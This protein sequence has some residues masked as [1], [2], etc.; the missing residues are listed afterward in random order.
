MHK[1]DSKQYHPTVFKRTV[2]TERRKLTEEERAA[3]RWRGG[4]RVRT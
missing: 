1:V 2:R 3:V 4:A